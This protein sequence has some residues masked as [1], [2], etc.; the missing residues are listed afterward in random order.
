MD[1]VEIETICLSV[2][3]ETVLG[4][5]LKLGEASLYLDTI[6]M[7]NAGIEMTGRL[8]KSGKSIE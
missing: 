5:T 7:S 2:I 6:H 1:P 8:N 3:G 4:T